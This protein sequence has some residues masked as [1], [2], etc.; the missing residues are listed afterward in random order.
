MAAEFI[1]PLDHATGIPLPIMPQVDLPPV[2]RGR[3]RN[4]A[5]VA[6]WHHPF[7]PRATL[8]SEGEL[9]AVAIRNCRIQWAEYDDHHHKY[10]GAYLGPELPEYE[11]DRFRTVVFAAA[12]YIPDVAIGFGHFG[13]P[14]LQ[15][16]SDEQRNN[17]WQ[18]G[19]I[20]V[21]NQASVRDFLLDY[22]LTNHLGG[23]SE[24]TID[25]FLST[26]DKRRKKELAGTI[27]AIV[28]YSAAEQVSDI[29]AQSRKL[30][31]IP[32]D[33]A[34]RAGRLIYKT[35]NTQRQSVAI[36]ALTNR[37]SA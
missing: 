30:N 35:M 25:Q 21:A 26:D 20:R 5:R 2:P 33:R 7:H 9:S 11:D 29:Y 18:S 27:L 13:K 37:L 15:K 8:I 1:T 12:G 3:M 4:D 19:Q 34:R 28:A 6:D 32:P 31:L 10:H 14:S 22:T 36:A 23:I 24:S 17:L 16:L